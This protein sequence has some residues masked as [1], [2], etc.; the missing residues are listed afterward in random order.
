MGNSLERAPNANGSDAL[1]SSSTS[2]SDARYGCDS[3]SSTVM[4]F[5][6]SNASILSIKSIALGSA[7]GYS[8]AK[9]TRGETGSER[10]YR[11]ALSLEMNAISDSGSFHTKRRRGGVQRRQKRS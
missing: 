7:S 2:W 6:G 11:R 1:G 3:A 9:S 8:L 5:D 10:M 4:R